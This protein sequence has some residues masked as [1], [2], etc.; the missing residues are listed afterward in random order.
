[1]KDVRKGVDNEERKHKN[2]KERA[3]DNDGLRKRLEGM[4][5]DRK[6]LMEKLQGIRPI[7]LEKI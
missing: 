2:M 4:K 5:V 3:K 7:K 1:M 6:D